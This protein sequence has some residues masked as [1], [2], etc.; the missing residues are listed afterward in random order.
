[1]RMAWCNVRRLRRAA[2]PLSIQHRR[3]TCSHLQYRPRG[4][5]RPLPPQRRSLQNYL[6]SDATQESAPPSSISFL[7]DVEGDGAYFDRF[8]R[9]SRVLAFRS[10]SPSHGRC[11]RRGHGLDEG[12]GIS[13]NDGNVVDWNVGEWEENYFPYDRDVVFVDEGD[14]CGGNSMLVYGVSFYFFFRHIDSILRADVQ[15]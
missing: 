8:V 13:G 7:T 6:S 2:T 3:G 5:G 12:G 11:A 1:M 14:E 15:I 10:R 4:D 9:H